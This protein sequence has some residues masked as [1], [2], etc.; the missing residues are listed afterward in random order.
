MFTVTQEARDQIAL[1]FEKNNKK[2]IR[3]LLNNGCR[4]PHLAMALDE[5]HQDDIGY[6]V[7]GVTYVI[8]KSLFQRIRPVTIHF[9]EQG[10]VIDS[11]LPPASGCGGCGSGDSCCS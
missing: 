2:P 7:D 4:G 8:E 3:L 10:F 6:D 1:Y 11:K 9:S 5:Q